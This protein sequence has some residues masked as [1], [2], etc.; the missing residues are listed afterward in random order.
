MVADAGVV[1]LENAAGLVA[2]VP[3]LDT[4]PAPDHARRANGDRSADA[5]SRGHRGGRGNRS[6]LP[7][8]NIRTMDRVLSDAVAARRFQLTLTVGFALAGL[9]LVGLGVYGVV[10]SAVE[11]RR[12]EI[13]VRLALGA[14]AWRVFSMALGQGMR[15][16]VVGAVAGLVTAAA[17]GR[18]MAAFAL[19]GGATRLDR[20]RVGDA[21][22]PRRGRC[23]LPRTGRPGRPHPADDVAQVRIAAVLRSL[24]S[25]LPSPCRFDAAAEGPPGRLTGSVMP[26]H[27]RA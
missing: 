27:C 19:R 8:H 16:V 18:A 13:A 3:V 6:A 26:I 12:S 2:Y 17:A 10:A 15:P 24:L 11:R 23:R 5:G 7:I 21:G 25:L 20:A 22:R 4:P 9:L 1:D 14:T